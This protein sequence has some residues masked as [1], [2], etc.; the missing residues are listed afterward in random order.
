M[1]ASIDLQREGF[2]HESHHHQPASPAIDN[3]ASLTET[4]LPDP[5]PGERDLLVEVNAISV[6]PVDTKIRA[7]AS[8]ARVLGWDERC[9][10]CGRCGRHAVAPGDE[11]FYAGAIIGPAPT[12][13]CTWSTSASS[14]ASP[15]AWATPMPQRS[16]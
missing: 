11:V 4:T 5:V 7:S 9:G 13:N 6:N 12:A 10:T 14:A 2:S 8:E 1:P 15:P 16:P 3:A